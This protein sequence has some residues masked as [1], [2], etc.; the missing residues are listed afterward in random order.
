MTSQNN[1][2]R[3]QQGSAL[4]VTILLLS[5]MLAAALVLLQ[6]IV[7][8][9]KSVRSMHDASQAYYTARGEV[10]MARYLFLHGSGWNLAL[11][12]PWIFRLLG[13][14]YL[15]ATPNTPGKSVSNGNIF[16]TT[17]G[18]SPQIVINGDTA[19][20][21]PPFSIDPFR[22]HVVISAVPELPFKI[23]FFPQDG[24]TKNLGT[25]KIDNT[26]HT[27]YSRNAGGLRFDL[28]GVKTNNTDLP[29]FKLAFLSA[30]TGKITIKMQYLNAV[31]DLVKT[32]TAEYDLNGVTEL[33]L[34][35]GGANLTPGN[36]QEIASN[37]WVTS[38][39]PSSF[40]EFFDTNDCSSATICSLSFILD[41]ATSSVDFQLI[42]DRQIPDLNAVV[43]GDGL[44]NNKLYYQRVIDLIPTPQD[45]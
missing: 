16:D 43:I 11:R 30:F 35:G 27:L 24:A 19:A 32:F 40:G 20:L 14:P 5:V 7:P 18:G 12:I 13:S 8:Y 33:V 44:S 23:K 26:Y 29:Q 37:W 38:G 17:T 34:R 1:P 4:I 2:L 28:R 41:T 39:A 36:I 21:E 9:A 42:S 10:D 25:S 22:D 31:N 6:R 45:L 3:W 15:S